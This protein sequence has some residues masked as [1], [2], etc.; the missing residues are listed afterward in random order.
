M[1]RLAFYITMMA[2]WSLSGTF[3]IIALVL[4]YYNLWAIVIAAGAGLLLAYP[5][6]YL[7]SRKV[8]RDD[9]DWNPRHEP[10]DFGVVPPADA[11]EV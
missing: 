3:V 7:I 2:A 10:G 5:A 6:G 9:P 8:K 11:P 1:D 4:G